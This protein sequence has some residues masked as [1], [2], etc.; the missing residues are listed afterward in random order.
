MCWALYPAAADLLP[1][2]T[3][4][5]DKHQQP[6]K[7][8]SQEVCK[9]SDVGSKWAHLV[10]QVFFHEASFTNLIVV[11]VQLHS[12]ELRDVWPHAATQASD[13]QQLLA[14]THNTAQSG[15][16]P[17][18]TQSHWVEGC[19]EGLPCLQAHRMHSVQ[20]VHCLAGQPTSVDR[21]TKKASQIA[22]L[23]AV[24]HTHTH[25]FQDLPESVRHLKLQ[26][27]LRPDQRCHTTPVAIHVVIE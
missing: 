22:L 3:D 2:N 1:N 10:S 26:L 18:G 24:P 5:P 23:S 4:H 8:R 27:G 17:R 25:G 21:P 9:M 11:G 19:P 12:G 13:T 14:V 16:R 7:A 6:A 15:Q 20:S